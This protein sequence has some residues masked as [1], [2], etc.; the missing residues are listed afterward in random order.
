LTPPNVIVHKKLFLT[1][2][3][4]SD[5]CEPATAIQDITVD[6]TILKLSE[7]SCITLPAAGIFLIDLENIF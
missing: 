3:D 4:A 7:K 5:N 2:V 1:L 6:T